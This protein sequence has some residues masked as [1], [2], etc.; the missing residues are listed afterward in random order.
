MVRIGI[1]VL[2]ILVWSLCR[3][4]EA[5][6]GPDTIAVGEWSKPVADAR[7][8]QVRGRLVLGEK[9]S[10]LE[11]REVVVY[12]ELQDASAS[13][14]S[15]MQLFCDLGKTDFRSESRGLHCQLKDKDKHS[16]PTEGFAFSGAV[17]RSEWVALPVDGTIRLRTSPFGIY[18]PGAM[19]ISPNLSALWIIR[20]DDPK[21]YFLSG[22]FTINPE[23][24]PNRPGEGH[25]WSGTIILPPVRIVNKR[26]AVSAI[27]RPPGAAFSPS[28]G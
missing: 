20:D 5:I 15:T 25:I 12:I 22:T 28:A 16:V 10:G 19:A 9:H 7:G 6:Q 13:I 3:P 23:D 8:Y 24:A 18:R 27:R 11:R 21:E 17:P 26:P 2:M 4:S 14:G 1:C